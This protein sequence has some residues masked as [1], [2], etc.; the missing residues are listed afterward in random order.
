MPIG[1]S[2]PRTASARLGSVDDLAFVLEV[3]VKRVRFALD[4]L[5]DDGFGVGVGQL[6]A[7]SNCF[8]SLA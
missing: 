2:G 4:Y 6:T 5:L 3:S 8:F 7:S 1:S